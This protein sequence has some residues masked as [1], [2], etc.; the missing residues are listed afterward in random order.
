[1]TLTLSGITTDVPELLWDGWG[2]Q[3][4]FSVHKRKQGTWL[5]RGNAPM[6]KRDALAKLRAGWAFFGVCPRISNGQG[7]KHCSSNFDVVWCEI[8]SPTR[9]DAEEAL[10][11][12]VSRL[13]Q[14]DFA[15]AGV[16]PSAIVYS[17]NRS[18]HLYFKLD[19]PLPYQQIEACN[20][21]LAKALGGDK[22]VINIDRVMRHPGS[23]H[24]KTGS[25][26][27]LLD[28]QAG[29]VP[30]SQLLAALEPY[31]PAPQA[32]PERHSQGPREPHQSERI[33]EAEALDHWGER[34]IDCA[35]ILTLSNHLK[36]VEDR[37]SRPWSDPF[38]PSRSE[39]EAAIVST[40]V[41]QGVSDRQIIEFGNKHLAKHIEQRQAT[42]DRYIQKL[43]YG[44]R[45]RLYD[46]FGLVSD[47]SGGFPRKRER[48][49]HYRWTCSEAYDAAHALAEGQLVSEWIK[50]MQS[51]GLALGKTAYRVRDRLLERKLIHIDERK[52]V[53]RI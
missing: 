40:L 47:P 18:P 21:S 52:R 31:V 3:F 34:D 39:I 50:Q 11:V 48:D 27:L 24:E 20:R 44:A 36:Y 45:E 53:F 4:L 49:V 6:A 43:I 1:M 15:E 23:L 8:D 14:T 32:L 9:I 17:G 25:P 29:V 33:R 5:D 12:A 16:H 38:Y 35:E 26:A 30:T 41:R 2:G 28:F 22:S 37:P 51:G 13:E 42:G 10:D 46:E 7:K 19:R